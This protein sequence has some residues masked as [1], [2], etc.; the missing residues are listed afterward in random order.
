M[1]E[2]THAE[3]AAQLVADGAL[4]IAQGKLPAKMPVE[5][6]VLS[7]KERARIAA[8]AGE[9]AVFY[10]VGETGVFLEMG[11]PIARV[12]YEGI[13]ATGA[14][15][16]LDRALKKSKASKTSEGPHPELKGM[17]VRQYRVALDA[18]RFVDIKATYSVAKSVKQAFIVQLFAQE[19][20]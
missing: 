1:A 6:L 5:A 4:A 18:K 2:L 19:K 16:T 10:P 7:D 20:R 13:D 9:L 8:K 11:G 17:K 15:D 3:L 14:I 12:W